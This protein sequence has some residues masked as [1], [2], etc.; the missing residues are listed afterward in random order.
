MVRNHHDCRTTTP[1]IVLRPF[2]RVTEAQGAQ[3]CLGAQ[4]H[5]G[6]RG[7]YPP[8][9]FG[10]ARFDAVHLFTP[11]PRAFFKNSKSW[12]ER[13][14]ISTL[15]KASTVVTITNPITNSPFAITTSSVPSAVE[16]TPY[17]ASLTASGGQPPIGGALPQA[18]CRRACSL[19]RH[20]NVV[21]IGHQRRNV[22]FQRAWDSDCGF[23][24]RAAEPLS[25]GFER[26]GFDFRKDLRSPRLTTV[27]GPTSA[28]FKCRRRRPAWATFQVQ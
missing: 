11:P 12:P 2:L 7:D 9:F 28:S 20:W 3:G 15:S 23:A 25:S 26:S 16:A 24:Y 14:V 22:C 6:Q 19:T 27:P 21:G 5:C 1:L 4:F 10:D 18:L 17:S 13:L 8:R